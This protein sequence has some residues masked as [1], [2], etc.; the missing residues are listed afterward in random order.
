MNKKQQFLNFNFL[1]LLSVIIMG[2]QQKKEAPAYQDTSLSVE[3]RVEDLVS[4]M[5]LEEKIGQM[6]HESDSIPRFS[7]YQPKTRRIKN[8]YFSL[9]PK[10]LGYFDPAKDTYVVEPRLFK[11]MSGPSSENLQAVDIRVE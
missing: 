10:N 4:R 3:E 1:F 8:R 6:V 5:T 9:T 11:V 2:C 7:A